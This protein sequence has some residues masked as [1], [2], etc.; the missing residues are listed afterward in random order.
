VED[1]FTGRIRSYWNTPGQAA[2]AVGD[3][4][5]FATCGEPASASAQPAAPA[6]AAALAAAPVPL[7]LLDGRFEV[8]AD[9]TDFAGQQGFATP[10]PLRSANSGLFW[11]FSP[12]NWEVLI[13]VLDGCAINDHY[14]VLAAATNDVGYEIRVSEPAKDRERVYRNPVGRLAPAQIDLQAFACGG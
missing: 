2:A 11:F 6:A 9:Y 3:I 12:D 4:D 5:A 1:R 7:E 10:T 8:A 13:K 14:W